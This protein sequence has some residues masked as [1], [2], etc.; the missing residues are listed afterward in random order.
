MDTITLISDKRYT[1]LFGT[2]HPISDFSYMLEKS[3]ASHH[4]WCIVRDR[5]GLIMAQSK[6]FAADI[7]GVLVFGNIRSF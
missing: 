5:D 1:G 6:D 2:R 7:R 4:Q 3:R